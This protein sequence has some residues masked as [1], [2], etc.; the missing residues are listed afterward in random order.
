[1][2]Q[3]TSRDLVRHFRNEEYK[4]NIDRVTINELREINSIK[5]K[6]NYNV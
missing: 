3:E 2:L 5:L 6:I 4:A 1:M